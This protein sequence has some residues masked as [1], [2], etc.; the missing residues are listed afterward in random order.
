MRNEIP[1][2]VKI[3]KEDINTYLAAVDAV[4][5]PLAESHDRFLNARKALAESGQLD[6]FVETVDAF[7][8]ALIAIGDAL[9]D[10]HADLVNAAQHRLTTV[11]P[12]NEDGGHTD[13]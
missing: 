1:K 13:G 2:T 10:A 4:I 6:P 11:R 3:E 5:I 8:D 7:G 9:L 12:K